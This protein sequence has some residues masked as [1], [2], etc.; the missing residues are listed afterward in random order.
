MQL[1]SPPNITA[2][3]N[4]ITITNT[5]T[6]PGVTSYRYIIKDGLN[7]TTIVPDS[8]YTG[9]V[10][11]VGNPG[12]TYQIT[13]TANS[14]SGA[15]PSVPVSTS[16]YQLTTNT[17]TPP[18]I[19]PTPRPQPS[20]VPSVLGTPTP[21]RT[22]SCASCESSKAQANGRSPTWRAPTPRTVR[23]FRPR[24]PDSFTSPSPGSPST[25]SGRCGSRE[26]PGPVP[27]GSTIPISSSMS[28]PTG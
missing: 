11:Y 17:S 4:I 2:Y 14:A 20:S 27:F 1:T 24:P 15:I 6:Q 19:P 28:V 9:P 8:A 5:D 16:I 18:P 22:I 21:D 3:G 12:S 26:N 7:N 13:I 23:S 10:T 25:S